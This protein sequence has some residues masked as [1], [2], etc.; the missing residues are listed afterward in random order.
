MRPATEGAQ[1]CLQF[2]VSV[3]PAARVF[4]FQDSRGNWVHHFNVPQR[5]ERLAITVHAQV[6]LD[7]PHPLPPALP[8]AA[9]DEVD[10]LA[11]AGEDWDLLQESAFTP[12]SDSLLNFVGALGRAGQ[13]DGD[14]LT[15]VRHVMDAIHRDFEYAPKSTRVD[16]PIDEALAARRGVCQDFSHIM[17]ATLRRIGLPC[18]YVSGYIAPR[19]FDQPGSRSAPI[20]THAWV[21]VRLPEL[22]W[23]G[24]DPTN[25]IDAGLRHVRVGIGRDY[26]DVPPTRGVFKGRAS[27]TLSVSVAIAP[28]DALPTIDPAVM[29]VTWTREQQSQPAIVRK[30]RQHPATATVNASGQ[31][32]ALGF[33]RT[34]DATGGTGDTRQTDAGQ[35]APPEMNTDDSPDPPA[36]PS[37]EI[38]RISN[39]PV[40]ADPDGAKRDKKKRRARSAWI[41]FA[42]R[43][44]AQVVGAAATIVSGVYVVNRNGS[45]S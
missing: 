4:A 28:G 25:N 32:L 23:I 7:A 29:Q 37:P 40:P 43:V 17:L 14:P 18:R 8:Q 2:D 5:H 12:W 30:Q 36:A 44:V 9:W 39:D 1:R 10:R 19:E 42:G 20:A 34:L 11:A 33:R 22:G 24:V 41:S 38:P 26:A 16:S 6:D 13:R 35:R 3:E 31:L 27:S 45:N 15:T 21:E